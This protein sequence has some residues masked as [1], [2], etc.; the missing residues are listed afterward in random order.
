LGN[1]SAKLVWALAGGTAIAAGCASGTDNTS[2]PTDPSVPNL[3]VEGGAT[4]T[5]K[6]VNLQCNRVTCKEGQHTSLSG[7]VF[8]PAG[9]VPLYNAIVYVPNGPLTPFTEGVACDRCGAVASGDPVSIGLSNAGGGFELID[10]PAGDNVPVVIQIGRWRREVLVDHVEACVDNPIPAT[11]THL[12]RNHREGDIPRFAVVT[13]SFDPLEC[14][15]RKIG[16]DDEEFTGAD[17][18]GRIHLFQGAGGGG[19]PSSAPS[20]D[21]YPALHRYDAVLLACEGDTHPENKPY[22][23]VS[24]MLSYLNEGG[25]V[26]ASHFQYYWFA[27]SPGGAGLPPFPTVAQWDTEAEIQDSVVTQVDTSFPKGQAYDKWLKLAGAID[28][29]GLLRIE[30]A[31]HDIDHAVESISTSWIH[32]DLAIGD[33][34]SVEMMTFNTPIGAP[35]SEQCGR[36]VFSDMHVASDDITGLTFPN[37]CVTKNLTSQEKALE[38]MLFDLSSCIQEDRSPPAPPLH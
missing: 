3:L 7:T 15:M 30:G 16:I 12:P 18:N 31:R 26:Y 9:Q 5:P 17:G 8:D 1:R 34:P 19:L 28:S 6:C 36:V 33:P 21:L 24:A 4:L 29:H 38:F 11:L 27:P 13:G 32:S 37:G 35:S 10:V 14:M 20:V 22:D 25:R 23:A 2:F